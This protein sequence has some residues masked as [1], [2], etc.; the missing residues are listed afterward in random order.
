MKAAARERYASRRRVSRGRGA[1]RLVA[2]VGIAVALG[3]NAGRLGAQDPAPAGSIPT[4]T[5]LPQARVSYDADSERLV[6]DLPPA[7]LPADRGGMEGMVSS[8]IYQAVIPVS[9]TAFSA[10]AF[11]FDAQG[12]QLPQTFLHHVDLADPDHRD[13]FLPI[14]LHI[15]AASKETPV[16]TVPRLLLGLPFEQGQHLIAWGML[17]NP[18]PVAYQGAHIRVEYGCRPAGAGFGASLFPVFRGYPWVID[19]LFPVGKRAYSFKSFDLPP[20]RISKSSEGSP[21]IAGT[22]VGVGGHVHD[23]AVRLELVDVTTGQV[24]WDVVPKRDSAGHVLDLPITTF[25][26]WHR[27]GLHITPEHRYRITV[28]YDNPTGQVIPAGGMGTVGGLF[29]PDRGTTWPRVDPTNDA[30][31]Q[32]MQETFGIGGTPGMSDMH[33]VA[34]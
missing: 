11:I 23:Y 5:S 31:V 13:L 8:P 27:L 33:M 26:N 2:G 9:C 18:T 12:R 34:H 7:D 1:G 16:L 30:Y 15:L 4:I 17:H 14:A 19:V 24:L 29:V 10:R 28:T 25:Y 6:I 3:V 21:A 32:D 20:G 22:I